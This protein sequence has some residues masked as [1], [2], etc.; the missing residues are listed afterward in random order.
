MEA[1]MSETELVAI[2]IRVRQ[3]AIDGLLLVSLISVLAIQFPS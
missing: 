2:Y 3:C 1:M